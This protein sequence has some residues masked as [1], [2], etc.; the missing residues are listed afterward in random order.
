[1]KRQLI[2]FSVLLA[3]IAAPAVSTPVGAASEDEAL[4]RTKAE[5]SAI[6]KRLAAKKR[7]A[8]EIKADVGALDAQIAELN[9]QILTGEHDIS[10]LES[11]IRS[12]EAQIEELTERYEN[13][14]NASAERARDLY[15]QGPVQA[16]AQLLESK[17]LSDFVRMAVWWEIAA[18]LDGQVMIKASRLRAELTERRDSLTSI[19]DDLDEQRRW[20]QERRDLVAAARA[21]RTNALAAV[22]S[23]IAAEERHIRELELDSQRLTAALYDRASRSTGPVSTTGFIWP[24]RGPIN[25]P[26]GWRR[27][28]FHSGIDIGGSYGARIVASKDGWVVGVQCGSGYGICTLLDHGNGVSTLYAHMSRK[29]VH[30]G[31]VSR[32]QVVGYVGCTGWCSGNHLHFEV[33]VNGQHRNPRHFLP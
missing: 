24:L 10:A 13:A 6:R 18:E 27:G 19:R 8:A 30:S 22:N 7:D 28:G 14:R 11:S 1:M 21:D 17:S 4:R 12:H 23:Q 20:L 29:A 26:Y 9:R 2:A 33:R 25:S 5:I 31:T 15:K 32:G 16:V 3:L